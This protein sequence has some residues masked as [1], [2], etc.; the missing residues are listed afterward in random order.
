M[1]RSIDILRFFAGEGWRIGG[2]QLP[3]SVPST[4]LYTVKEPLGS[5][6]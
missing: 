1:Q 3:S 2:E 5:S 4:H 6:G